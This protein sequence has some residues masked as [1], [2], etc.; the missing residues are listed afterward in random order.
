MISTPKCVYYDNKININGNIHKYILNKYIYDN[1]L[2]IT[3]IK[4]T[5]S[6]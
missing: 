5:K 4:L 1:N 6:Q 2:S 3:T